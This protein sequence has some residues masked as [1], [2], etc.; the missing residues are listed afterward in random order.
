MPTIQDL[1]NAMFG[2]EGI[3]PSSG[4][5]TNNNPG[6]LIYV[7]QAGATLGANGFAAFATLEDG[8]QAAINQIALDLTRGTTASG[9]PTTTLAQ[10]ISN[11]WSPPNAPGNSQASTNAYVNTV[12]SNLG[13]DPNADLA[14]QIGFQKGKIH[15]G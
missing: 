3:T 2:V 15:K 8:I 14:S 9:A 4:N 5:F 11:G 1:A 7:G 10:L 13:I 12:A 6:D